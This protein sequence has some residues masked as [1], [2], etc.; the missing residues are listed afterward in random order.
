MRCFLVLILVTPLAA[1][2][3]RVQRGLPY[4]MPKDERQTLDVYT[5]AEGK[6]LP[7]IVWIHGGAWQR[8]DKTNVQKKPQAFTDRGFVF[9]STNYRFVPNVTV[10]EMTGDIARAIRWAH[11]HAKEH[12]G[13]PKAIYLMGHSAG[14]HLAALVCTDDRYLKAE[15]LSLKILKG[16]VPVDVSVYDIPKR[17]KD[18]GTAPSATFKTIFGEKEETHRDLSPVTHVAKGKDIPPFLILHVASRP[19]TKAQSEWLADKLKEAGVSAAVHAAEG[20][21]HGTINSE[22]GLPDDKPTK[23][24]Y[25]FLDRTRKK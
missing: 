25:E 8:G 15:G 17:F 19:D 14:A 6:N 5:P 2:E 22:L 24:L 3:P 7:V 13:D 21:T 1:A 11:D 20:K 4:A 12:G 10:K 18:G 9:I 23:A 16:C